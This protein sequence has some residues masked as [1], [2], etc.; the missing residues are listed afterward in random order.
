LLHWGNT[1]I[2]SNSTISQKVTIV[3]NCFLAAGSIITEDI[4]PFI[5]S[6]GMP[7]KIKRLIKL[8]IYAK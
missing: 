1:L 6:D 4:S 5:I 2:G 7:A 8:Y 3:G